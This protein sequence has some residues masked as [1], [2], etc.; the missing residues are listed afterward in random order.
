M[1]ISDKNEFNRLLLCFNQR[2]HNSNMWYWIKMMYLVEIGVRCKEQ[3]SQI[4]GVL[5][6]KTSSWV[7]RNHK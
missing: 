5:F 6:Y 2:T 3:I 7:K 1:S 4:S